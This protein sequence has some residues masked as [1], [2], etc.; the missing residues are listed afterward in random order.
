MLDGLRGINKSPGGRVMRI[1]K[2]K[3]LRER[4]RSLLLSAMEALLAGAT[5]DNAQSSVEMEPRF[6]Q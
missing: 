4:R 5:M 2:G 3:R 6:V 1:I